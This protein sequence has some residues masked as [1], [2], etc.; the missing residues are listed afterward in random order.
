MGSITSYLKHSNLDKARNLAYKTQY[1]LQLF[2]EELHDVYEFTNADYVRLEASFNLDAFTHFTDIFFDNL[3]S[4][5]I[6]QRRI[7]NG[8]A[9]IRAVQDKVRRLLMTLESEEKDLKEI[10]EELKQQKT[11]LL[12]F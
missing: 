12:M 6:V 7:R 4:D 1:H 10:N 9:N 5:W 11:E 3:I 2:R 8:L